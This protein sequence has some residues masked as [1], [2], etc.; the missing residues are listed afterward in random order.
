[1]TRKCS[2]CGGDPKIEGRN[3]VCT[4]CGNIWGN[5]TPDSDPSTAPDGPGPHDCGCRGSAWCLIC[6]KECHCGPSG[7]T[8]ISPG[9]PMVVGATT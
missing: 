5:D 2:E 3:A 8:N 9:E 7:D 4:S 6:Q 1:M